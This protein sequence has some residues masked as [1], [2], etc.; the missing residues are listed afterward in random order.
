MTT[1]KEWIANAALSL[2]CSLESNPSTGRL[3]Y[4]NY[5]TRATELAVLLESTN[6]ALWQE[7]S[8]SQPVANQHTYD[9]ICYLRTTLIP[10]L[11]ESGR[12]ATATDFEI[13]CRYMERQKG[14]IESP[15][16]D[17]STIKFINEWRGK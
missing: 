9:F 2:I 3:D 5:I 12:L 8:I 4:K 16:D 6:L 1:R 17:E 10:D 13:A 11:V 15:S 14:L 7:A